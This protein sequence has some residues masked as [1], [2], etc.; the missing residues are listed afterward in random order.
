MQ[1]RASWQ[2]PKQPASQEQSMALLSLPYSPKKLMGRLN[3]SD[4]E[5]AKRRQTR[6]QRN[7]QEDTG[8]SLKKVQSSNT[9]DYPELEIMVSELK[10]SIDK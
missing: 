4:F 9:K 7:L 1:P 8:E 6:G 5:A 3:F 10:L 2:V